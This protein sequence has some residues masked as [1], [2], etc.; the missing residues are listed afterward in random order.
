MECFLIK[1][2]FFSLMSKMAFLSILSD[3][4]LVLGVPGSSS[5]DIFQKKIIF[6][7]KPETCDFGRPTHGFG[8][9]FGS[10]CP[11]SGEKPKKNRF[12]LHC[13]L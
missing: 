4:G 9:F 13:F 2:L 8:V 10:G 1:K 3:F 12:V 11:R 5:F 7:I 6:S